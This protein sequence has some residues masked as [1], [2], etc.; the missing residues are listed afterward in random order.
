[1]VCSIISI[2]VWIIR[3]LD[4]WAALSSRCAPSLQMSMIK[5][6][7]ALNVCKLHTPT[8]VFQIRDEYQGE[9]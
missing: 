5:E 1:M 2:M 4:L 7:R 6:I 3:T 9:R 8:L